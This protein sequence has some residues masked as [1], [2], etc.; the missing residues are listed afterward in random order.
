[1]K[2]TIR[3]AL[4]LAKTFVTYAVLA[5][6]V[7]S[8]VA[9]TLQA[10]DVPGA[11]QVGAWATAAVGFLGMAVTIVRNVTR[12][13]SDLVGLLLPE[14]EAWIESGEGGAPAHL[15]PQHVGAEGDA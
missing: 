14:D 1:M 9:A 13:G 5:S 2:N 6:T 15:S 7:L 11:V 8:G 3:R 4:V 12:V 10:S